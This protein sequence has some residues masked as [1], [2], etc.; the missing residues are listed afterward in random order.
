MSNLR[1][2]ERADASRIL[3]AVTLMLN[4]PSMNAIDNR[5]PTMSLAGKL[6]AGM[7]KKSCSSMC[8]RQL[9]SATLQQYV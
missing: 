2:Y 6:A 1:T 5:G 8:R 4:T 3:W 7:F 9:K